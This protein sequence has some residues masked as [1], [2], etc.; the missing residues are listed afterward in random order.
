MIVGEQRFVMN[1]KLIKQHSEGFQYFFRPTNMNWPF[2]SRR[3]QSQHFVIALAFPPYGLRSIRSTFMRVYDGL[4]FDYNMFGMIW[5]LLKRFY[6]LRGFLCTEHENMGY[7]VEGINHIKV[8]ERLWR[9]IYVTITGLSLVLSRAEYFVRLQNR[10]G[11]HIS[12]WQLF[13][14]QVCWTPVIS[15][16]LECQYGVDWWEKTFCNFNMRNKSVMIEPVFW[17]EEQCW[18]GLNG[19]NSCPLQ[20]FQFCLILLQII[21]TISVCK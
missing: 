5:L 4:C 2:L 6:F 17:I 1:F 12:W 18:W 10:L 19:R 16:V 11:S 21:F 13:I 15:L 20:V 9:R 14:S 3:F 8:E 7:F